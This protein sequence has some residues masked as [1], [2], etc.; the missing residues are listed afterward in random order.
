MYL[1]N[2]VCSAHVQCTLD[3]RELCYRLPDTRYEPTRFP[4]LIWKHNIIKG[5]CLVFSNGAIQCQ[6]KARSLHEGKQRLRRYARILQKTGFP[7]ILTPIKVV[8][9]SA[10]HILSGPLDIHTLVQ[11]RHLVYE[12]ELFPTVNMKT[13]GMTFSCYSNGKVIITGIK[14][15]SDI[16]HSID[17]ILIELELYTT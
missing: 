9:A 8:T 4:G 5:N 2:V 16:N 11:E 1:T 15:A 17:P 6:G 7:V 12:P 14:T 10:F 3:L 13:Q